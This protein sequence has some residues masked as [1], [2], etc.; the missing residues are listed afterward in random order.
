MKVLFFEPLELS[1]QL[2]LLFYLL[3]ILMIRVYDNLTNVVYF[4]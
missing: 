4:W 3:H 2:F 1:P